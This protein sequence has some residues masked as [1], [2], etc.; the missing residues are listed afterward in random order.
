MNADAHLE[1]IRIPVYPEEDEIK[2]IVEILEAEII[3]RFC[4]C[5]NPDD[6]DY[7]AEVM[8]RGQIDWDAEEW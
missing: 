3:R 7:V 8:Y 5:G 2:T 1:D 4:K 6:E